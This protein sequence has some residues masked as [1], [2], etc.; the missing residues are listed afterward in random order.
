[1]QRYSGSESPQDFGSHVY[2][3][4]HTHHGHHAVS[5]GVSMCPA[6]VSSAGHA[7][8]VGKCKS[9]DAQAGANLCLFHTV[10]TQLELHK[11]SNRS[12]SAPK[13]SYGAQPAR[14]E[15]HISGPD[16]RVAPPSANGPG[17]SQCCRPEGTG[18]WTACL[19]QLC[20]RGIS[21]QLPTLCLCLCDAD[22]LTS[23]SVGGISSALR[24][25]AGSRPLSLT[26][27]VVATSPT[28]FYLLDLA[29]HIH[30]ADR[31]ICRASRHLIWRT[32]SFQRPLHTSSD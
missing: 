9:L 6:H 24:Q 22:P 2:I 27:H 1:M 29:V 18:P 7:L 10:S 16:V 5:A 8:G 17:V 21:R 15:T 20:T 13:P 26:T 3:Q 19:P 4:T 12:A 30:S 25:T 23:K 28:L 31:I 14:A 32:S 11:G